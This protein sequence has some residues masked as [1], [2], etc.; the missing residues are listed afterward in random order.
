MTQRGKLLRVDVHSLSRLKYEGV[1][2]V[3]AAAEEKKRNTLEWH[4]L[5][6]NAYI[7]KHNVNHFFIQKSKIRLSLNACPF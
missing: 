3:K 6:V 2:D 5:E 1:I 4:L 7:V